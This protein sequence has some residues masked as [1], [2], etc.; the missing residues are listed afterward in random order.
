MLVYQR[1]SY[2]NNILFYWMSSPIHFP[3]PVSIAVLPSKGP[4]GLQITGIENP[5]QL[6]GGHSMGPTR[7]RTQGIRKLDWRTKWGPQTIAK[8][9]HI[10]PIAMV[11]GTYNYRTIVFM[12]FINHL[13]S[14]G[15]PTLY[16]ASPYL[17]TLGHSMLKPFP[18]LSPYID[19]TMFLTAAVLVTSPLRTRDHPVLPIP[20]YVCQSANWQFTL[21]RWFS[22]FSLPSGNLR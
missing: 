22:H 13:T 5:L 10:T 6:P 8:L 7:P 17:A 3:H 14:L 20:H 16:D 18:S 9:V 15:G 11:Y 19:I 4:A 21:Y 12:G 1:V 2:I